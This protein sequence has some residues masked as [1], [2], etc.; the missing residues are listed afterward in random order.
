LQSRI[1][2]SYGVNFIETRLKGA[3]TIEIKRIVDE[4]GFFARG[5]CQNEFREHGLNPKLAQLN[6]AHNHK[7]G[8]LRGMHFQNAPKAEAKLVRC[9]RGAIFDVIIDLRRDSPTHGQWIGAELTAENHQ[10]LYV[11]EGFAHGYQTLV[12]DTEIYYLTSEFYAP[13]CASGVKFDDPAFGIQ[14]PLAVELVSNQD[15]NWPSYRL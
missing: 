4:R 12:D 11:P 6:I 2:W 14:W 5:W 13:G 1:G 15:R 3:Y 10:M 7:S 8:T 9:T